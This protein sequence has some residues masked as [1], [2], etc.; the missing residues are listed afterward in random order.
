M[1]KF[2][3]AIDSIEI[4]NIILIKSHKVIVKIGNKNIIEVSLHI[5]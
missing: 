2:L 3:K 4:Y 1:L 5:I